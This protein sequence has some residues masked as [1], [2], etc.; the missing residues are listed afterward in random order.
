MASALPIVVTDVGGNADLVTH[1]VSGTVVPSG[2]VET[3]ARAILAYWNDRSLAARHAAAARARVVEA[4]S[5]QAMVDAYDRLFSRL[6]AV[7]APQLS[8]GAA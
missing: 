6:L 3:M 1:G 7:N 2:D 5:M 8:P 4:F